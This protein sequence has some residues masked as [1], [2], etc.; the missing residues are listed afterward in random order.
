MVQSLRHRILSQSEFMPYLFGREK[1]L[2]L[3]I[4]KRYVF[5]YQTRSICDA[6]YFSMVENFF[7]LISCFFWIINI[8]YGV[9]G[10]ALLTRFCHSRLHEVVTEMLHKI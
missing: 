4:H 2:L 6:F 8:E 7:L 9:L 5:D 10:L 3:V 1:W